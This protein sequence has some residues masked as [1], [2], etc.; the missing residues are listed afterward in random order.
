M[1]SI[2]VNGGI[3]LQGKV[4]IQ[5]SK[6]AALPILAA[7]LLVQGDVYLENCPKIAD[8][9][10]M[11]QILKSLGCTVLWEENGLRVN[12]DCM[13]CVEMPAEAVTGMR[14]SLCLLGA[15]IGRNKEVLMEYPGGCVIGERPIDIHLSALEKM[16]VTFEER[17]SLLH[18]KAKQ[19]NGCE[20]ELPFASVGATENIILAAVTASGD[21]CIKGAAKEP[22]VV[23][24]CEFLKACGAKIQG[25]GEAD[26]VIRGGSL[27]RGVVFR[28]PADR[29]VAGT[30]LF[31]TLITK[32]NVYLEQAPVAHMGAVI[33][34]ACSMGAECQETGDGLFVQGPDRLMCPNELETQVYP[35]FPT[36]L[37]SLFLVCCCVA[38][39]S[40]LIRETI[41]ENRFR[42]TESMQHMGADV[43]VLDAHSV[44]VNGVEKIK[45]FSVEAKELRGGA[46]LVLAGLAAVGNTYI[47]GIKFID[48]GYENICRD[49]RELGARIT[50]V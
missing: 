5:G 23:A 41:F 35:G 16:G 9:H 26:L 13:D 28:I 25:I 50:R 6:N 40:C 22:E 30:Y 43:K 10:R 42:I 24:L 39:G 19:L 7:C 20:L 38:E 21:T 48:R 31:A 29:I 14:S 45:G 34:I 3:P 44:L 36:D 27:L 8:V 4:R 11:I 33:D 2:L 18:A 47:S 37:Q 15:L 46:A 49:L 1:G 32:G 12:T 17:N